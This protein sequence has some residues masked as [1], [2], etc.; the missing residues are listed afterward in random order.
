[1]K[2]NRLFASGL[3]MLFLLIFVAMQSVVAQDKTVQSSSFSLKQ[4]QEMARKSNIEVMNADLDIQIAN[5]KKKEVTGIG[6]P[7]LS[8]NF[9]IKNFIEIPTSLIPA[10]FFGG[11]EGDFIPVQFGTQY[12]ATAGVSVSQLLFSSDYLVG[13]QASKTFME[14]SKKAFQRTQIESSAAVTKAY[15][16]VL[17]N[18]KQLEYVDAGVA[19]LKKFM[20]DSKALNEAGFVEKLDVDRAELA[21]N[22]LVVDRENIARLIGLSETLLKFQMGYDV[23][24]PITLTDSL[25]S[26]DASFAEIAAIAKPNYSNRIEYSLL[27]TQL[28]INELDLKRNRL[29][30][31]PTLVAYGSLSANALRDEFDIFSGVRWFPTGVIG[32]TLNVSIFDGLQR[33]YK[34]QQAHASVLKSKNSLKGFE[35]VISMEINAAQV[36]YQNALASYKNQEKNMNLAR[37]IYD[38]TKIKFEQGVGTNIEVIN[39]ETSMK[40]TRNNYFK[41]LQN[42]LNAKVDY[43]KATGAIK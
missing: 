28:K 9:D 21:Y 8:G 6:F 33:H 31:I 5:A 19:L 11:K 2:T 30:Y 4:A 37:S 36:N 42:L 29:G 18:Q 1:M 38:V 15:Y 43:D 17:V 10:Q 27:E 23:A 35:Q 3:R 26:F 41:A 34:I 7:Q 22:N 24:K 14:L 20:D 16:A 40:E 12:Q 32:A 39:A 25:P 13:L